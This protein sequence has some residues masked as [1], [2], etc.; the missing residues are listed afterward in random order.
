MGLARAENLVEATQN[1]DVFV[2]VSGIL[3]A[4]ASSLWK[5][6]SDLR[7]LSSGPSAGLA[8]IA[9]PARQAGSSIM[10]GKVNP[11]IPEAATQAAMQVIA[12]DQAIT[13]AASSG[14]LELNPF[15]PLIAD[16]LLSSVGLLTAACHMLAR[17]CVSGITANR[18][19]CDAHVHGGTAAVT[20]LAE[21]L[22]HAACDELATAVSAG[23]GSLRDLVV[24]RGLLSAA[25]YDGLT[26]AG[27]VNQLGH[28]GKE[29]G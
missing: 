16:A 8:E 15:L 13:L 21:R 6:C 18:E 4:C 27:R 5:V 20:A 3:K 26:S 24:R 17:A 11:V 12:N 14:S 9:L 23:E 25:E 29:T 2:E 10:P 1:A 22:G 28:R 19:R 7:L